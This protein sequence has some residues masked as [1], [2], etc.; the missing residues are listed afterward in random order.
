MRQRVCGAETLPS[1]S[2]RASA[3][4]I[5]LLACRQRS[6]VQKTQRSKALKIAIKRDQPVVARKTK[7]SQISVCPQSMWECWRA[8]Q[9]LEVLVKTSRF[10]QK[11]QNR[12][13]EK[14]AVNGPGLLRTK[15]IGKHAGVRA[16]SQKHQRSDAAKCQPVGCLRFPIAACNVMLHMPFIDQCE[17]YV[18]VGK[19]SQVRGESCGT[20]CCVC[21]RSS[22]SSMA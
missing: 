19:V 17:P 4:K 18:D 16:Q 3:T 15:R 10:R 9:R 1:R 8:G 21:A 6:E 13:R 22:S 14:P 5:A 7:R 2:S 20:A 11:T 12:N